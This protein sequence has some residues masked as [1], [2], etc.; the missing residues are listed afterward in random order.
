M[1]ADIEWE[2]DIIEKARAVDTR[3]RAL[4][5]R[6]HGLVTADQREWFGFTPKLNRTPALVEVSSED[7]LIDICVFSVRGIGEGFVEVHQPKLENESIFPTT[8]P[9]GN[10]TPVR[11]S[12]VFREIP[13]EI[14]GRVGVGMSINPGNHEFGG[15]VED[16]TGKKEAELIDLEA[17][18][19]RSKS[20]RGRYEMPHFPVNLYGF[21][22]S[23][24]FSVYLNY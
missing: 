1:E 3:R 15:R 17:R 4:A 20:Q 11:F 24:K 21:Q 10:T 13:Y 23:A 16:V 14:G 8:Y 19:W 6:R 18:E 12:L 22:G 2:N 7:S 9:G 5:V